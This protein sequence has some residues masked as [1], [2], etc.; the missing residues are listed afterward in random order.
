M[1]N[2]NKK[3][4][5][6]NKN[7]G[8]RQWR[9]I[10]LFFVFL[11]AGCEAQKRGCPPIATSA[12]ATAVLKGYSEGLKPL[13]A[14]GNCTLSYTNEVGE[15][16]SQSFPVRIWFESNNKFC[17]YGDVMFDP[18]GVCFAVTDGRYWSYAKPFGMYVKGNVN[19]ASEDYFSNPTVLV[20]FL[21]PIG[22]DCDRIYMA[23][24]EKNFN[25]LMCRDSKI[26]R[27]KKIFIDRCSKLVK[28]IE[29]LNCAGNPVLAVEADEYKIVSGVKGLLF[30][31]KLVYK[32]SEGQEKG[33]HLMQIKLDSVQ[34]WNEQPQQVKALFTEPD[35]NS[36]NKEAK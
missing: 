26:C 4:K 6:K 21:Q 8:I 16:Y 32:Y 18:K 24:P 13:K 29:Y 28:K 20:D 35:V 11:F 9:M 33:K 5:I 12:E 36:I 2:K 25:L 34:I 17:L 7:C 30:P 23:G 1:D 22:G 3:P 31:R 14:T 27:T 15:K 19:E 10:F